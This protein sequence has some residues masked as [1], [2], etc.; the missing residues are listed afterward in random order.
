MEHRDLEWVEGRL[1]K[2]FSGRGDLMVWLEHNHWDKLLTVRVRSYKRDA[3]AL[4]Q[5]RVPYLNFYGEVDKK[6]T[7]RLIRGKIKR[8]VK[9]L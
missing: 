7:Y 8:W 4:V 2:R 1:R 9:S 3:S 6:K 5:F